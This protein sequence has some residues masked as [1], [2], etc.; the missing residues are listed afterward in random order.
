MDKA[1][2]ARA[3]RDAATSAKAR[4][5]WQKQNR[6]WTKKA[7]E[8]QHGIT[9]DRDKSEPVPEPEVQEEPV[10]ATVEPPSTPSTPPDEF[11]Y[12]ESEAYLQS[13]GYYKPLDES[14][15]PPSKVVVKEPPFIENTLQPEVQV[16][17]GSPFT[18]GKKALE[19]AKSQVPEAIIEAKPPVIPTPTPK[20][21]IEA[22][23]PK[24]QVELPLI[25]VGGRAKGVKHV[26]VPP[27]PA[28]AFKPPP[29]KD[30]D[31]HMELFGTTPPEPSLGDPTVDTDITYSETL[32]P[33]DEA[34]IKYEEGF[35]RVTAPVRGLS[36]ELEEKAWELRGEGKHLVGLGAYEASVAV[37]GAVGFFEGLT[38]A[39]RPAK[40]AETVTSLG[41]L[42]TS[43]EARKQAAAAITSNPPAFIAEVAGG[44]AGG[45]T[46]SKGVGWARGKISGEPGQVARLEA[47]DEI[48]T[49]EG[50]VLQPEVATKK[51]PPK[52]YDILK[53]D[54]PLDDADTVLGIGEDAGVKAP[55]TRQ[56]GA[57]VIDDLL[58]A[59]TQR[60][61]WLDRLLGRKKPQ[62][63]VGAVKGTIVDVSDDAFQYGYHELIEGKTGLLD[64]LTRRPDLSVYK[65][66]GLDSPWLETGTPELTMGGAKIDVIGG[67]S[68]ATETIDDLIPFLKPEGVHTPFYKTFNQPFK[69]PSILEQSKAVDLIKRFTGKTPPS[70]P[71]PEA[72]IITELTSGVK[73][74]ASVTATSAPASSAAFAVL[75]AAGGLEAVLG[76]TPP[77]AKPTLSFQA[78]LKRRQAEVLG[79][80]PGLFEPPPGLDEMRGPAPGLFMKQTSPMPSPYFKDPVDPLTPKMIT[81]EKPQVQ[82]KEIEVTDPLQP[83]KGKPAVDLIPE[84]IPEEEGA[85][86]LFPEEPKGIIELP[87]PDSAPITTPTP[88]L[89]PIPTTLP[90]EKVKPIID[91][92]EAP[93][94]TQKQRPKTIPDLVQIPEQLPEQVITPISDLIQIPKQKQRPKP[95]TDVIGLPKQIPTFSLKPVVDLI[96]ETP[97]APKQLPTPVIDII[98]APVQT[99]KR[100]VV[101]IQKAEPMLV[102]R[103][104]FVSTGMGWPWP[105]RRRET[106]K[107]RRLRMPQ[108][109]GWERRRYPIGT[110]EDMIL[111]SRPGRRTKRR[112]K[113]R[114]GTPSDI[115]L[116]SGRKRAKPKP[117]KKRS[118]P[119]KTRR[120]RKR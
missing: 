96:Q 118:K 5:K 53:G 56:Y 2:K 92:I 49:S 47:V 12:L 113:P 80:P 24:P 26:K 90:K 13:E 77:A 89:K 51:I 78:A 45:Y 86:K 109:L 67:L 63:E 105:R 48:R 102:L 59:G 36:T 112:S 31:P 8:I 57:D 21:I 62:V 103:H 69:Y 114:G 34:L 23:A 111:G 52:A 11:S 16:P 6:K 46:F 33:L 44:I 100:R 7:K 93:K 79:G 73:T 10:E 39:V 37:R 14:P 43:P 95:V 83:T 101:P 71:T 75:M 84:T 76:I 110:P 116:G 72:A 70:L 108:P 61:S 65:E 4:K 99:P 74:V 66:L 82:P 94:R 60:R 32:T 18:A 29:Q 20:A 42:A 98:Q 50:T 54:T 19:E 119:R 15:P 58:K 25:A 91:I 87:I 115:L 55:I 120:R 68:R 35:K 85:F 9:K 64:D 97:Q 107:K 38:F 104:P 40:W 1:A 22:G 30:S 3:K 28:A 27:L 41:Q 17:R 117:R 106:P 81:K 88:I